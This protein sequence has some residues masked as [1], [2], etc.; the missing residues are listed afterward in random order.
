METKGKNNVS[1]NI[2]IK[3][4]FADHWDVFKKTNLHKVPED[5]V[6]SVV[7]SVEKM[8]KCGDPKH[9]Y[10]KYMCLNCGKHYKTIGFSC[11][12]RF[13]N[14]CGKVYIENWV[15]KQVE[16]IIDVS[17][18]HTVFTVPEELRGLIYW[19]RELLKELSDG[20]AEVI[21][22]WYRNRSKTK[23]YEVAKGTP[24]NN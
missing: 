12:S 11:K 17:H 20:V 4:I 21:Q 2:K 1:K 8:L 5:M 14:R 22:Y 24:R 7:E 9:G 16:K 23:G 19:N 6:D 3:Q 10:A 13:C 15:N 18:K